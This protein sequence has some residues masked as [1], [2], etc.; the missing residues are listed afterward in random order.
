MLLKN[1]FA[2]VLT[3]EDF[4]VADAEPARSSAYKGYVIK[5]LVMGH[6]G[7]PFYT[8]DMWIPKGK[9]RKKIELLWQSED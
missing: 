5:T 2:Y 3:L 4:R 8:T 6:D 7:K 1:S 9:S